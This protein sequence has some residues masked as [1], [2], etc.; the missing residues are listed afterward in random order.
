MCCAV[1]G[2]AVLLFWKPAAA[3]ARAN[4]SWPSWVPPHALPQ[5]V[6]EQRKTAVTDQPGSCSFGFKERFL[7][8]EVCL[9]SHVY[10]RPVSDTCLA[11]TWRRQGLGQPPPVC[12]PN[13]WIAPSM[14]KYCK[15]LSWVINIMC[16]LNIYIDINFILSRVFIKW[17]N[18]QLTNTNILY[19]CQ[20]YIVLLCK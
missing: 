1:G 7:N 17:Y 4:S 10:E 19:L 5:V 13:N 2:C 16:Q 11:P 15:W 12:W 3:A 9:P 18:I 14:A 8:E 20:M 6:L